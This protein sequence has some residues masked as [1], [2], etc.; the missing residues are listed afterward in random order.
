MRSRSS[1]NRYA[2]VVNISTSLADPLGLT[3]RGCPGRGRYGPAPYCKDGSGGGGGGG[4]SNQIDGYDVPDDLYSDFISG[5]A[6]ATGQGYSG[7]VTL[8]GPTGDAELATLSVTADGSQ[9][10]FPGIANLMGGN[11]QNYDFLIEI[12]GFSGTGPNLPANVGFFAGGL[13]PGMNGPFQAAKDAAKNFMKK[14]I[15]NPP[16]TPGPPEPPPR[17]PEDFQSEMTKLL[18]QGLDILGDITGDIF[19][20]FDPCITNPSLGCGPSAPPA[21]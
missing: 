8:V 16:T 17:W 6:G 12:L 10:N 2:Y 14:P 11:S 19:V 5:F 3:Y 7:T 4:Y 21:P 1:W 15:Q 9:W 13:P 18:K 20:T